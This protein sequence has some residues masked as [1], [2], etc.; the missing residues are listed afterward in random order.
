MAFV[1]TIHQK[2]QTTHDLIRHVIGL[3]YVDTHHIV[4]KQ[5]KTWTSE[6]FFWFSFFFIIYI[7]TTHDLIRRIRRIWDNWG[8][9]LILYPCPSYRQQ[10]KHGHFFWFFVFFI[11]FVI[12]TTKTITK[13][14]MMDRIRCIV[15]ILSV[16]FVVDA[17]MMNRS[18][19][20]DK[21]AVDG[22]GTRFAI[23]VDRFKSYSLTSSLSRRK[24]QN[25]IEPY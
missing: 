4:N 13:T 2:I 21:H 23:S 9:G 10:R 7:Q 22:T 20:T 25:S 8:P 17:S 18:P 14:K 15:V 5:R 16:L 6:N 11:F 24:R 1:K 3:I 19:N 12:S